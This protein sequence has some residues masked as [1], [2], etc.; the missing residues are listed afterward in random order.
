MKLY[1]IRCLG[2]DQHKEEEHPVHYRNEEGDMVIRV[3]TTALDASRADAENAKDRII[4][5]DIKSTRKTL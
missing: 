1:S 4:E 5:I 3:F 2:C